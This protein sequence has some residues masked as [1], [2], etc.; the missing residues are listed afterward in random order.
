M[1]V[2]A[3]ANTN[4]YARLPAGSKIP[5]ESGLLKTKSKNK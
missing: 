5:N 2:D 1:Q 3:L 4:P